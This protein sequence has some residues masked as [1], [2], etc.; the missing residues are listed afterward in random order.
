MS[1]RR[2]TPYKRT[3]PS[4]KVRW[5]ARFTR[6]DG[7]RDTNGTFELKRDAQDAIN[8][9][10]EDQLRGAPETQIGRAHV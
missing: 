4:G 6:P 8:Q 3:Y 5:V 1:P 2:E 10:Y 9:A 7:S